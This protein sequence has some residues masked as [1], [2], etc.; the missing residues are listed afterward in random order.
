MWCKVHAR[1]SVNPVAS[2]AFFHWL[3]SVRVNQPA[4]IL[5]LPAALTFAMSYK[6]TTAHWV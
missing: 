4:L 1:R 3:I 2:R 6:Y 5:Y